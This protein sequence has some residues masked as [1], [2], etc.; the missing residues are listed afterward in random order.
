[1]GKMLIVFGAFLVVLGAVA[2]IALPIPRSNRILVSGETMTVRTGS[3]V[4]RV[5]HLP[6]DADVSGEI[7]T[8]S[9]GNLDIDFYLFDKNNYDLWSSGQQSLYY[10]VILRAS[11]GQH[12]S[13]TTD[14]EADYYFVFSNP[15][16]LSGSDRSITWSASYKYKPYAP[17]AVPLLVLLV[18]VGTAVVSGT[19]FT[20]IRQRARYKQRQH[21]Q[22]GALKSG[23]IKFLSQLVNICE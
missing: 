11:G 8:V 10:L 22:K 6:A 3:S 21:K 16:V 13:S 4:P 12:F 7:T 23:F 2:Y 20:D 1:M 18:V 5:F 15:V 17:F 19:Y 14:K 9:G